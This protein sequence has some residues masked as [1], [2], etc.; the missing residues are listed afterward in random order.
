LSEIFAVGVDL[1]WSS[2][3]LT[4]LAV[5]RVTPSAVAI[6]STALARSDV[7]ILDFIQPYIA[8]SITV[9]IDAPTV[10]PNQT[11]MRECE[12]LL[13][14]DKFLHRAHSTPYPGNRVRLGACNGEY[15]E[16]SNS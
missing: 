5:A 2:R 9:A 11:G 3:H 13:Q 14:Q 7:E 1:A 6:E 8:G 16:A 15:L 12:R 10:I 4:G